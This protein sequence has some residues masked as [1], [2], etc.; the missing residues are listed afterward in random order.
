M[1]LSRIPTADRVKVF[2]LPWSTRAHKVLRW[3]IEMKEGDT[4]QDVVSQVTFEHLK[5]RRNCGVKTL[6]E[7]IKVLDWFG[8]KMKRETTYRD[9]PYGQNMEEHRELKRLTENW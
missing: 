4:L 7:I 8:L 5:S 2:D 6:L 1:Y 3:G 9:L